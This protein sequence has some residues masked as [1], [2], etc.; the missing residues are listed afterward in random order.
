MHATKL[1]ARATGAG[2]LELEPFLPLLPVAPVDGAVAPPLPSVEL[3]AGPGKFALALVAAPPC[4]FADEPP[5]DARPAALRSNNSEAAH[6]GA[7]RLRVHCVIET[8]LDPRP[9]GAPRLCCAEDG[10]FT[11]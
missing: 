7:R 4:L 11:P 2:E 1:D 10:R 9:D 5:H 3:L 6:A 8:P